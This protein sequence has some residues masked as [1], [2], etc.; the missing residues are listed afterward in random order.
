MFNRPHH[1]RIAALLSQLDGDLLNRCNTYFAGGTA[2][3]L[4][5]GE[6]RESVDVDFLCGSAEGYRMLR[7][8]VREKPGLDGLAKSPIELMRDVKTD[9]YGIRTFAQV[10]GVPLKVEFVLE[11]RIAIAGQYSPQLGVPVLCRDDMYAEKLLANDDRQG[12]RQSMNRDAIDLALMIDR[13]GN[14]PDAALSKAAGAYGQAVITSFAK[15]TQTLSTER[16]YLA[17]C[18]AHMN[19]DAELVDRIPAV[20]QAE[21]HRIAPELARVPPA[22]PASELI[23]QDPALGEFIANAKAVV[24]QGNYDAGH[25]LG[26]VVWAGPRCCAQ[27]VGRGIVVLHPTEHWH[28]AP[29]AGDYVRVR[30]Q[31]GVADWAVVARDSGRDITR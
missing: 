4:S 28:A 5:A 24:Q 20:L 6:Y 16:D 11:G 1:Q 30:Y 7:E 31:H 21:L 13:W 2:I 8:A 3:V 22:P 9:Q 26:R 10:D 27:D 12:D 14:I 19:M 18:L 17:Q 29:K 23:A 15:A 25:Y